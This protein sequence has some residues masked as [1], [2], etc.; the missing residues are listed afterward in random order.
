MTERAA[1][2]SQ[3]MTA[4]KSPLDL[5]METC[6]MDEEHLRAMAAQLAAHRFIIELLLSDLMDRRSA[7][8]RKDVGEEIIDY[9]RRDRV[10]KGRADLIQQIFVDAHSRQSGA[11]RPRSRRGQ[12]AS[13]RP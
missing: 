6:S 8:V 12:K 1:I 3:S 7:P 10:P 5:T 2:D 11:T 4:L 9:L 13:Q